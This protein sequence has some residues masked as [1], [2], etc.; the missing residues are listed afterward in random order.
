VYFL[1]KQELLGYQVNGMKVFRYDSVKYI[2]FFTVFLFVLYA[3]AFK[4]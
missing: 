1:E 2:H 4:F 3:F